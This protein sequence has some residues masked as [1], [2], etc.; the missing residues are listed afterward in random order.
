SNL[1]LRYVSTSS[2]RRYPARVSRYASSSSFERSQLRRGESGV[3]IR[4]SRS[5]TRYL[6]GTLASS[7]GRA[8]SSTSRV[9]A[10]ERSPNTIK[11]TRALA[12]NSPIATKIASSN[13]LIS[14]FD[15]H[16]P[17]NQ[18][19]PDRH[20]DQGR[21]DHL[22]ANFVL[23]QGVSVAR[24]HEIQNNKADKRKRQENSSRHPPLG[25]MDPHLLPQQNAGTQH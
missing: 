7:P 22:S 3:A 20:T 6:R 17:P 13:A 16:N 9:S 11:M 1:V 23:E 5:P 8:P 14:V 18:K 19:E 21:I 10:G 15:P 25:R 4:D 24:F 2:G 12:A